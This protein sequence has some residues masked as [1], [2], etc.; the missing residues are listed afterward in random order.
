MKLTFNVVGQ[1]LRSLLSHIEGITGVLPLLASESPRKVDGC[2]Q[3]MR[4]LHEAQATQNAIVAKQV[5]Q[6]FLPFPIPSFCLDVLNGVGVRSVPGEL[7]DAVRA[8]F[9]MGQ[10]VICEQANRDERA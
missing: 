4:G 1:R 9:S 3:Y 7:A 10:T 6:S 8:L 2:L 5:E